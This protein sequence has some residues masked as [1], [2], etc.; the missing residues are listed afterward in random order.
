M[1]RNLTAEQQR[2][3]TRI[4]K[5][6]EARQATEPM[7][8]G[9]LADIEAGREPAWPSHS[10]RKT[11]WIL[12]EEGVDQIVALDSAYFDKDLREVGSVH[13]ADGW[14][15]VFLVRSDQRPADCWC[16][17]ET[18]FS[19]ADRRVAA[20]IAEVQERWLR[21][22]DVQFPCV[23]ETKPYLLDTKTQKISRYYG[24]L[25]AAERGEDVL[26]VY[27]ALEVVAWA[28]AQCLMADPRANIGAVLGVVEGKS[29]L[30]F[31]ND[32]P[33][34]PD[35][36]WMFEPRRRRD[37]KGYVRPP[38]LTRDLV[39]RVGEACGWRKLS[40]PDRKR[41]KLRLQDVLD[42][43]KRNLL[44][45]RLGPL[46]ARILA[47]RLHKTAER[48]RR[49]LVKGVLEGKQGVIFESTDARISAIRRNRSRGAGIKSPNPVRTRKTHTK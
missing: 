1:P 10:A 17:V 7:V 34:T 5:L 31:S 37:G 24:R 46:V 42:P 21:E 28:W 6:A 40:G 29:F 45:S 27:R 47:P 4:R 13:D 25:S 49:G 43:R 44:R 16:R 22:F 2:W 9:W 3:V 19:I 32:S 12:S 23:G 33:P 26:A 15:E 41:P 18:R 35:W 14:L 30:T 8:R 11:P 20:A 36:A 48:L 39:R 38:Q